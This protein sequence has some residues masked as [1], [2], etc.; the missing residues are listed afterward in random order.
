MAE[1]NIKHLVRI[2]NTDIKGTQQ[3]LYGLKRVKGVG[4]MFA[5]AVCKMAK[6]NPQKKTG[7]LSDAEIKKIEA[8]IKAPLENNFP[9]WMVN[10]RKDMDTGKDKH[11]STSDLKFTIDSGIKQMK[12]IRSYVGVRHMFGLPVRGQ[13]TRSNFRPNKGKVKGVQKKK[14]GKKGGK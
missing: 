12:K 5:N 7:T 14:P 4:F 2:A 11:L 10:R 1:E 8:I 6:M 3:I 9:I 13:R